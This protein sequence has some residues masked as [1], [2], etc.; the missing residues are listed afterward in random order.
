MISDETFPQELQIEEEENEVFE[1][2]C[3]TRSLEN[4]NSYFSAENSD[5]SDNSTDVNR[6]L[7]ETSSIGLLIR[8]SAADFGRMTNSVRDPKDFQSQ[9]QLPEASFQSITDSARKL[10]KIPP[11]KAPIKKRK[12]Y[13]CHDLQLKR[14]SSNNYDHVESKVKKLIQNLAPDDTRKPF[15]RTKSMVSLEYF[16]IFIQTFKIV[17]LFYP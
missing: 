17:R 11:P 4:L 12:S 8:S 5:S 10:M 7:I 16:S 3:T 9:R 2:I 1:S 13:S 14:N 15:S 6:S